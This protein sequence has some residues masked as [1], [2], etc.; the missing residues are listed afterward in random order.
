MYSL[1]IYLLIVIVCVIV[2]GNF[3]FFS[4]I[5]IIGWVWL[6]KRLYIVEILFF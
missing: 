5:L 2:Y 1:L 3:D 6:E 4:I